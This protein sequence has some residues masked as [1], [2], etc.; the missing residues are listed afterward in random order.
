VERADLDELHF[1]ISTGGPGVSSVT[2]PTNTAFALVRAAILTTSDVGN[3]PPAVGSGTP[4][5]RAVISAV[6]GS[7][8]LK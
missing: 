6:A 4:P 7:T 3:S 1:P 5:R 2:V 8:I